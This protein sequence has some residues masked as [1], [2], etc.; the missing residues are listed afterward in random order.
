MK[1]G[2]QER[3]CQNG[4]FTTI[5]GIALPRDTWPSLDCP[6]LPCPNLLQHST[7]QAV[8]NRQQAAG[9]RQQEEGSRQQA[10]G[11]RRQWHLLPVPCSP[12]LTSTKVGSM[13]RLMARQVNGGGAA[14]KR[15]R[16][17][18]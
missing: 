6:A 1:R 4:A 11:S 18:I 12:S 2:H 3:G 14:N 8:S 7:R 9:S 17:S 5:H 13:N 15:A 16:E 10:A